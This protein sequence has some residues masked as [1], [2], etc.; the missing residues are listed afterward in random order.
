MNID[1]F[2]KNITSEAKT[3]KAGK[4]FRIWSMHMD[5]GTVLRM[6][7]NK[8]KYEVGQRVVGTATTN[9]FGELEFSEVVSA[10]TATETRTLAPAP[11]GRTFPLNTTSPEMSIVRQNA[12]TNANATVATLLLNSPID[13]PYKFSSLSELSD[14]VIETAYKYA[15]FSSGQREVK[16]LKHMTEDA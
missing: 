9:R 3:S 1:N 5:D 8:P 15:E 14:W 16:M 13:S 7:F 2:V 4:P 11:A 10:S 6:G 12:L